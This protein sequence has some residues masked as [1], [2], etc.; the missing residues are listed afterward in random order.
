MKSA[1]HAWPTID[2][3]SVRPHPSALSLIPVK[4]ALFYKCFPLL[5]DDHAVTVVVS[6]PWNTQMVDELGMLISRPIKMV[7]ADEKSIFEIIREKY[8]LG[9][10]NV[11]GI[12]QENLVSTL[13]P[14]V[15]DLENLSSEA[16]VANLI[17]QVLL[18]GHRR[19]ATDVHLEPFERD[20]RIRYRVDGMLEDVRLPQN[21]GRFREAMI[22]R[23]KIMSN[24]NIAEKRL[25]QDGRCKVKAKEVELDLRISCLPSSNGES[26]VIRILNSQKLFRIAELGFSAEHLLQF[27]QMLSRPHGILFVTG[28]TG[29]GKTTTLYA[30]LSSLNRE[31]RKIITIEDPIEYQIPGIVQVAVNPSI[32]LNFAKGLRSILRHDP[33]VM[34]VGEVRDGETAQVA[35]QSA[36]T[37]HLVLSTVHTNDAASGIARLVD[38]G[39]EPYLIVS[40][41]Q[42]FIA[43]RLV[44]T[45]CHRCKEEENMMIQGI[46][47]RTFRGKG[48]ESCRGTGYRGRQAIYEFLILN[49]S[50]REMIL[51]RAPAGEIKKKAVE[52]GMQTLND[53]GLQRVREGVISLSE[54]LRV[55][56]E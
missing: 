10:E 5:V 14:S 1:F 13:R 30:G 36:L 20:F 35:I 11:Q 26:V 38:M 44:R 50:L 23:I 55:T 9:A 24:L 40:S 27:Q 8:G 29:S 39:I 37:G 53:H 32:G 41:V 25:P 6:D 17:N 54:L 48:C 19:G 22:S 34:M 12:I 28:P 18:E 16:S 51:Q 33:D 21:I 45:L 31:A 49:D 56:K 7:L 2:L 46:Q 15:L 3:K 42:C 4:V 52:S 47:E 43:Q